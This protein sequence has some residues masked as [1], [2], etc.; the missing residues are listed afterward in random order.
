MKSPFDSKEIPSDEDMA[1]F[2]GGFKKKPKQE[3]DDMRR[4]RE[5]NDKIQ[6][7]K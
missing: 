3:S 6:Q 2:L 1:E 5:L 7:K 4:M